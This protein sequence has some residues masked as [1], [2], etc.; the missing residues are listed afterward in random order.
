MGQRPMESSGAWREE[1]DNE[2]GLGA[3]WKW[4]EGDDGADEGDDE[5]EGRDGGA[6]LGA[7]WEWVALGL[8]RE[9]RTARRLEPS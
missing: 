7:W 1:G 5:S 2:A 3:W 6:G 8:G 4:D 9:L